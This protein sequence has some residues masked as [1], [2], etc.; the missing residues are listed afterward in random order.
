MKKRVIVVVVVLLA[1]A[2]GYAAWRA[3]R[4]EEPAGVLVASGTVE[5]TDA[6]LGFQVP[7]RLAEV[8]V[9]EGDEVAAGQ[10]LARLDPAT[11]QARR[12]Q[13]AAQVAAAGAQL[14]DLVAGA[15][16]QEIAEARAAVTAAGDR[17]TDARR[18]LART[19]MLHEGGALPR[20]AFDKAE[21][22]VDLT[23]SQLTQA[24]ERLRLLEAGPRRERVE[25]QRAAVTQAEA[26]LAGAETALA[27]LELAAPFAGVVTV[28]HREP[29]EVVAAGQPAL[30][31]LDL[32]DRWVK[33][34]VPE[35]RVGAVSLGAHA[36]ITTD[37]YPGRRF[38]GAVRFIASEAEFTPKTVQTSEERVRLVYA[39]E[40]RVTGD[41]E[42]VLKPGMPADVELETR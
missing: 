42:R 19:R 18:D 35:D 21:L 20:E 23:T 39:V 15:R 27:D 25:A 41:P 16:R 5:A 32:D 40:V 7:G 1:A 33:I 3:L 24:E 17:Q 11:A 22:A 29:G 38:D 34:Y 12:D 2:A 31:L 28:R 4:S 13:A 37:T 6:R 9:R 26:A 8:A 14:A 10:L 30:T 36:A